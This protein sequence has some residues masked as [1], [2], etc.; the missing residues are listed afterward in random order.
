MP[1]RLISP[2]RARCANAPEP[3]LALPARAPGVA[4]WWR[5]NYRYREF[6][7]A[8][9]S[10]VPVTDSEIYHFIRDDLAVTEEASRLLAR[11]P[12]WNWADSGASLAE[13]VRYHI[14]LCNNRLEELDEAND[15]SEDEELAWEKKPVVSMPRYCNVQGK[16][17]LTLAPSSIHIHS[18]S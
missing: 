14:M 15:E 13:L 4:C 8:V 7:I 17:W 5:D 16:Q 11:P 3:N 10:L 12:R 6:S 1:K 18:W 9:Y 2:P